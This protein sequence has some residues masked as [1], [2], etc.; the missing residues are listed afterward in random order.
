M[1]WLIIGLIVLVIGIIFTFAVLNPAYRLYGL[2]GSV[3]MGVLI[4]PW[5]MFYVQD[6][7]EA[8]VLKTATGSVVGSDTT[9][10]FDLKAPWVKTVDY[11]IRNQQ[12]TFRGDGK[13]GGD[14]GA[15]I[16]V[17]DKEGVSAEID[18][19]VRYSI[20]PTAVEQIHSKYQSQANF[21]SRFIENDI[22]AGV[23]AVPSGFT[24]LGLLGNRPDVEVKLREYLEKRWEGSGVLVES[25]S[26]QD[27][28]YPDAVKQRFSDAQNARTSV[29]VARAKLEETKVSAEAQV[30]EAEAASKANNLLNASL[31]P[32]ILQHKQ[33]ETLEKVG[34]AGN[35]IVVPNGTTPFVQVP[36]PAAK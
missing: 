19:N 2:I 15:Q 35:T 27:I 31:T 10:G 16:T 21:V 14:N 26:L 33:L 12:V 7:G 9:E 29:E 3:L 20:D 28:R 23:R 5:G 8:K 6:V 22:R 18:I 34:A 36:A 17:Q 25:V 13:S 1:A 4:M 30:V 11:D 24:T 32:E